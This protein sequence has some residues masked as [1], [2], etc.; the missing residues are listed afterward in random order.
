MV[1]VF[2]FIEVDEQVEDPVEEF[3]MFRIES[4]MKDRALVEAGI[5]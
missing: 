4:P 1:N 2:K 5:H 3:V